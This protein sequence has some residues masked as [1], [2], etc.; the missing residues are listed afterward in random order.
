MLKSHKFYLYILLISIPPIT[1]TLFAAAQAGNNA[2]FVQKVD[3]AVKARD[4]GI[5]SYSV[6]EHYAVFRGNDDTHPAAE[7]LVKTNYERSRGKSYAIL[8]ESGSELLRKQVLATILEREKEM[9][10]P[11]NRPSAVITSANYEM[12]VRG[13]ESKDGRNCLAVFLKPRHSSPFLFNGVIWTDIQDGTIDRLEGTA[14]KSATV[15]AGPAQ[16]TRQYTSIDG[17][18]MAIHAQA[19]SQSWLLGK[20]IVKIDYLNYEIHPTSAK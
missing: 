7:M 20:T 15:F 12:T 14:S 11:E 8:E 13:P 17:F 3:A 9:S 16:V 1:L 10:Q 18:P 2:D 5:E 19:I 6:T 4:E